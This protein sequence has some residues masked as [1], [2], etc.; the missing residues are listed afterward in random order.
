MK[1]SKTTITVYDLE[2]NDF[3]FGLQDYPIFDENY[4]QVLNRSILDFYRWYEIGYDNPMKWKERINSK[5]NRIMRDKY[6]ALY[7]AKKTEFNPLYN[8]DITE[9]FDHTLKQTGTDNNTTTTTNENNTTTNNSTLNSIYPSDEFI[10]DDLTSNLFVDNGQRNKATT[11]DNGNE[12]QTSGT[13]TKTENLEHYE[14]K[15]L[16]SSAGLPFSKA[17][18][19]LKQFYDK[20]DLDRQVCEELKEFFLLTF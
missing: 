1:V 18:I 7:E 12:T 8:I 9:T 17:L 19:Q 13:E 11:T 3:D 5:L 10:E 15:Q 14:R 16:G 20:Y 4:R 2:K 6:N